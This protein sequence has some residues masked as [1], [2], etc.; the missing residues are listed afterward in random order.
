M[1]LAN[2]VKVV[3]VLYGTLS[4]LAAVG[5]TAEDGLRGQLVLFAI[6]G[7]ALIIFPWA[8]Y[9]RLLLVFGLVGLHIAA[10]WQGIDQGDFH[11]SHHL[12]RGVVSIAILGMYIRSD[13][14][15]DA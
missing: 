12:V 2:I 1:N 4:L 3:V 7:L 14:A 15:T 9:Q 10:I 5:G 11:I 13:V 8:P 6:A